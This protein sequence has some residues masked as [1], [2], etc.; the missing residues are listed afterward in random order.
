MSEKPKT[1]VT[2]RSEEIRA[3]KYADYCERLRLEALLP[4]QERFM[5]AIR[6]NNFDEVEQFLKS[7]EIDVNDKGGLHGYTPLHRAT[8][9]GSFKI[10]QLLI[11]HGGDVRATDN[12]SQSPLHTLLLFRVRRFRKDPGQLRMSN[13]DIETSVRSLILHGTD[14][15][16]SGYLGQTPL[17][18]AVL[19][20]TLVVVKILLDHGADISQTDEKGY[21]TMHS[22]TDRQGAASVRNKICKTLLQH[23]SDYH[24]M[25]GI[26]GEFVYVNFGHDPEDSDSSDGEGHMHTAEDLA[27]IYELPGLAE[28]LHAAHMVAFGQQLEVQRSH[29]AKIKAKNA[30]DRRQRKT[31]LAM[32]LHNRL[33]MNSGIST[34]GADIM[35]IIAKKM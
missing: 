3:K 35:G 24:N 31:A 33:G 14:V 7:G 2:L 28:I 21:N 34:L 25:L 32:C 6:D 1:Q 23:V 17:Q 5:Y 13:R 15:N 18:C 20:C 16:A 10:I 9:F 22:L 4:T 29:R 19:D 11:E 12:A 27:E 30:E 8:Q 26:T